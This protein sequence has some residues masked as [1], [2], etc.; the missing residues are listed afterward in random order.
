MQCEI[1]T[2]EL[3]QKA[4]YYITQPFPPSSKFFDSQIPITRQQCDKVIELCKFGE[5]CYRAS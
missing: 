3:L 4:V 1:C 2:K 5:I